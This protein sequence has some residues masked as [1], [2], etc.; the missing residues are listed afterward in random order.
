MSALVFCRIVHRCSRS[1][2]A[3]ARVNEP[4]GRDMKFLLTAFCAIALVLPVRASVTPILFEKFHKWLESKPDWVQE[5]VYAQE[6]ASRL[7]VWRAT[8]ERILPNC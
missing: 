3:G 5:V 7:L 2:T 4:P 1:R 6:T 8:N